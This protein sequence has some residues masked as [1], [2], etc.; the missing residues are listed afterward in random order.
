MNKN[1]CGRQWPSELTVSLLQ[2]NIFLQMVMMV[3]LTI[4][5]CSKI[6]AGTTEDILSLTAGQQVK[7]VWEHCVRGDG[8]DWDATAPDYELMGS[9]TAIDTQPHV[10]LPGPASYASP[11]ISPSGMWALYTDTTTNVLYK[12]KMDGTEKQEVTKGSLL[13]TWRNPADQTEWIYSTEA[14]N[15]R[16]RLVRCRLD[17]PAKR[18]VMLSTIQ[19]AHT[20]SVSADGTRAGS[21][22]PWP[23]A[24]V[25]YL[26]DR[27]WRQY[28]D[29]CN[30]GIAPD[31]SYRF[32][33]MHH[34]HESI[35]MYEDGG[36]QQRMIKTQ[37]IPKQNAWVPRWS[38]DVRFLTITAPIAGAQADVY[39]GR[40]D[41]TFTKVEK[42]VKVSSAPGQDTKA[43]ALIDMGLGQFAGEV[44]YTITVPAP[45]DGEWQWDFGDGTV[46]QAAN[47][48]HTYA[49]PGTYTIIA[50]SGEKTLKGR[51][52]AQV[53]SVPKVSNVTAVDARHLRVVFSNAIT[54]AKPVITFTSGTAVER[55]QM[56][57][58]DRELILTTKADLATGDILS[59]TGVIDQNQQPNAVEIKNVKITVPAWPVNRTDMLYRWENGLQENF[60]SL[61]TTKLTPVEIEPQGVARLGRY[62]EM[63]LGGGSFINVDMHTPVWWWLIKNCGQ[64]NEFFVELVMTPASLNQGTAVKPAT[65]IALY[66]DGPT[67][68]GFRLGQVQ[69]QLLLYVNQENGE[70]SFQL[71][72]LPDANK[73]HVTVTYGKGN[74]CS[75]LDGKPMKNAVDINP[76]IPGQL[77]WSTVRHL[78]LGG[79]PVYEMVP[80]QGRVEALAVYSRTLPSEEA[81]RNAALAQ[82]RV[83]SRKMAPQLTGEFK[84]KAISVIP[85]VS[86]ILPYTRTL[87]VYEYEL[88]RVIAGTRP[89]QIIRVAHWGIH[90]SRKL[91]IETL[92][93]NATKTLTLEKF[94]DCLDL[95]NEML[96]DT[97][98]DNPDVEVFVESD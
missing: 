6:L 26:P 75:Y 38:T 61:D 17:E 47:S 84:L 30:A 27:G 22:F 60:F 91:A 21:E 15:S 4:V 93:V 16:G 44:P 96:I 28:G 92:A 52:E 24:G 9:D 82:Q 46:V 39:L 80:W 72:V 95:Q 86:D 64:S 74:V 25:A 87:V 78:A 14:G 19:A 10:I 42:W 11:C 68:R 7:L 76:S 12:V 71:G 34:S 5:V 54:A 62:G 81:V 79:D 85:A 18:E 83:A 40:F 77:S 51:M 13:C 58:D 48:K 73:H 3:C 32:F 98:P 31:N 70:K 88:V 53:K 43:Y 49:K 29:G 89:A 20:L 90:N 1:T 8:T 23:N 97:L 56:S 36:V 66:G 55:W 33:H 69:D 94:A 63:V 57:G 65:I 67:Q 50:K 37:P 41:N 45:S 2:R 59:L 35:Q